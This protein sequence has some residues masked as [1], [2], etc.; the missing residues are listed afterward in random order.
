[1]VRHYNTSDEFAWPFPIEIV[2]LV[3]ERDTARL[4][5]KDL[6]TVQDIRS[7]EMQRTGRFRLDHFLAMG[8]RRPSG[9]RGQAAL[10]YL[11]ISLKF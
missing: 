10:S 1:M 2:K 9:L 3:K 8:V 11:E 4:I 6:L 7:D 5:A